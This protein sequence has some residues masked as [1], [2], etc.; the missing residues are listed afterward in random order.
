M[1]HFVFD[2]VDTK[3]KTVRGK[4]DARTAEEARSKIHGM[5]YFPTS[6]KQVGAKVKT[7]A[8]AAQPGAKGTATATKTRPATAPAAGHHD[9]H[10][11][12]QGPGAAAVRQEVRGS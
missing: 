8:R 4:V 12:R 10:P 6:I 11:D 1:V 9:P 7:K 5:N 3:G 2:A